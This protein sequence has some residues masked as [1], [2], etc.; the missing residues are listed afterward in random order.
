MNSCQ[1]LVDLHINIAFFA[2]KEK[3][4]FA[5]GAVRVSYAIQTSSRWKQSLFHRCM[6]FWED[7]WT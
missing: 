1:I 7:W 4:W 3:S 6:R 2:R 5:Q